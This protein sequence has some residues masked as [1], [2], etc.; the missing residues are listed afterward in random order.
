MNGRPAQQRARPLQRYGTALPKR[1]HHGISFLEELLTLLRID[2]QGDKLF[3]AM[4]Q[5]ES[6]FEATMAELLRALRAAATALA[7]AAALAGCAVTQP[8]PPEVDLPATPA[9]TAAQLAL[10][11]R[12]WLAFGDPALVALVDE[13]LAGNL[14]V[15]EQEFRTAAKKLDNAA[16]LKI[17][18]KNSASRHKARLSHLIKVAKDKAKAK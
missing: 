18:H 10:L 5:S 12:W 16:A 17:I 3:F 8:K 1:G 4:S 15:A 6:D 2:P 13:A 9:P 11:E 7:F 14:D